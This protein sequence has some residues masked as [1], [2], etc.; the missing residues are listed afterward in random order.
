MQLED[1]IFEVRDINLNRLG[2]IQHKD[3]DF[4]YQGEFNNVGQWTLS[5]DFEH[6]MTPALRMPGSGIIVTNTA[7]AAPWDVVMSGPTVEPELAITPED[8][9]GTVTFKGVTDTVRLADALALPTPANMHNYLDTTGHDTRTGKAETLLH[10][11]VSANIGPMYPT[12]QRRV[13]NLI[14]GTDGARGATITK[15]ARYQVLGTLLADIALPDNLGFRIVQRGSNLVFETYQ[16]T[17]RTA[18]IRLDIENGTL[19]GQRWATSAPALTRAIV[20]GQGDLE[21]RQVSA[22]TSVEAQAAETE[23]G[24]RIEKFIDQRQT[25]DTNEHTKAAEE[26]LA[27]GG[28]TGV[29]IQAVPSED[30]AMRYGVDWDMG[31]LV[32]VVADGEELTAYVLGVIIKADSDG[33]RSGLVLGSEYGLSGSKI[34]REIQGMEQRISSL[35]RNVKAGY[36]YS[37][38]DVHNTA[39]MPSA[40]RKGHMVFN[41]TKRTVSIADSGGVFREVVNGGR[42]GV[43]EMFAGDT[44]PFGALLCDGTIYNIADYPALGAMLGAKFGGN[45]TTTFAVPD[46]RDRAPVGKSATK[47]LGSTGGSASKTLTTTELPAH[48]HTINHDHAQAT[49]SSNGDHVHSLSLT[50]DSATGVGNYARRGSTG[51]DVSVTANQS[52]NTAGAHT[53]TVD[54]AAYSGSSGSAGSGSSFSIQNPY[55]ALNFIIY[56]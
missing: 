18:E 1:L 36:S 20:A 30:T 54:I 14:M 50:S 33:F 26:A 8:T 16:A 43:V 46:M 6:P 41:E 38:V 49:T 7:A 19:A 51:G 47:A 25:E 22:H 3:L 32:T 31:D 48:T 29:V 17:D 55:T 2:V 13:P 45:G 21:D 44:A 52:V 23:W 27:E 37:T 5:L 10:Q 11:Y 4:E 15:N 24:R 9:G 56:T 40:Q 34:T 39:G 53:H 42:T 12:S 35:E 28:F